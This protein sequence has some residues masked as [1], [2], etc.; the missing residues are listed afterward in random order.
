MTDLDRKALLSEID[1]ISKTPAP[2][3]WRLAH[4]F[5]RKTNPEVRHEQDLHKQDIKKLKEEQRNKFG[6]AAKSNL[7]F[8]ISIPQTTVAAIRAFDPSFLMEDKDRSAA[9]YKSNDTVRTLA[10]M[11]PE[12]K[13]YKEI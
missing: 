8:G 5:A 10:K 1:K 3:R 9:S 6:S 12:Y 2:K 7:R 13:V 4:D 11:F